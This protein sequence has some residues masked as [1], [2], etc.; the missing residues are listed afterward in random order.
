MR[1]KQWVLFAL[2]SL[3]WGASFL[4]IKLALV[5]LSPL[6]IGFVRLVIASATMWIIAV[7]TG[8]RPRFG[9]KTWLTLAAMGLFNNSL[10]FVLIPWGE[11]YI[12]SSLAAILN[13]TVPLFTIVL[14]HFFVSDER[15]TNRRVGGLVIGFSG[16]VVLMAP[17]TAGKTSD[18]GNLDSLL[19]RGEYVYGAVA[20]VCYA[21]ATVIGRRNLRGEQPVL[22]S[23]TQVSF[24]ALWLLPLVLLSGGLPTLAGV[25]PF[26]W[27]SMLWLGAVGSGLAYLLYFMLLREVGATQVVVVTY[28]LPFIGVTLGVLLLNE[29]LTWSMIAGLG[30]ILAGLIAINGVPGRRVKPQPAAS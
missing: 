16:V 10:A 9:R 26:I 8:R 20:S 11:Q 30:L 2:L 13:S 24:G 6:M 27:A 12:P 29:P 22:T 21:I 19:I 18:L 23:A 4:F 28:V 1:S 14:A 25:S 15:L 7:A 17:Q 3:A 5:E